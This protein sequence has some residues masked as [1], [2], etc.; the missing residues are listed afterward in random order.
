MNKIQQLDAFAQE[1]SRLV[2]RFDLE[3]DLSDEDMGRI[4]HD[5]GLDLADMLEDP[6]V[7]EEPPPVLSHAA[8]V[9]GERKRVRIVSG[10]HAGDCMELPW[11]P[12]MNRMSRLVL[13]LP[14]SQYLLLRMAD[15]SWQAREVSAT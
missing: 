3:F 6:D 9:Q 10:A 1:V 12:E 14:G 4:L 13:T 5:I 7:V 8:P 2:R 11:I 15:G